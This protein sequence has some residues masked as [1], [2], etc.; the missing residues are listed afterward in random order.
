[1]KVIGCSSLHAFVIV[2]RF[3]N[4]QWQHCNTER[5][6]YYNSVWCCFG[7]LM[8]RMMLY[9][10]CLPENVIRIMKLLLML[11]YCTSHRGLQYALIFSASCNCFNLIQEGKSVQVCG[12]VLRRKGDNSSNFSRWR[13]AI[14]HLNRKHHQQIPT[15]ETVRETLYAILRNKFLINIQNIPNIVIQF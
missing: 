6:K 1:M 5:N 9:C 2:E 13:S 15:Q 10:S 4:K 12:E 11:H 3:H 8:P 7:L 14:L